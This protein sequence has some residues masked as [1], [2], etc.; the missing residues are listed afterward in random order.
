MTRSDQ[1]P[2]IEGGLLSMTHFLRPVE[3]GPLTEY[4]MPEI[5]IGKSAGLNFVLAQLIANMGQ[6][7]IIAKT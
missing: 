4:P 6:I 2:E 5:G 1:D 7:Y 3:G